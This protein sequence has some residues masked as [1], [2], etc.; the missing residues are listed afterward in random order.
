MKTIGFFEELQPN[1]MIAKSSTRIMC[2]LSLVAALLLMAAT[3]AWQFVTEQT[4]FRLL[5]SKALTA[6]DMTMI[7]A[8]IGP[9][10]VVL[11]FIFTLLTYAFGFKAYNKVKEQ[12]KL[13]ST[14]PAL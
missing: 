2:I 14:T 3:V 12:G 6:A 1:G 5:E 9:G 7:A 11:G 8:S 10:E 4:M 13:D